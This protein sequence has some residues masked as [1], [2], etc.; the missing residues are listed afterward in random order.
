MVWPFTVEYCL[1]C[2]RELDRA[3]IRTPCCRVLVHKTCL[4][5][6]LAIT[7]SRPTPACP[8]C[9]Q[10]L[11]LPCFRRLCWRLSG[12]WSPWFECPLA[13]VSPSRS[14]LPWGL[15][16]EHGSTAT[17]TVFRWSSRRPRR[18]G[19]WNPS[20]ECL[21]RPH[22]HPQPSRVPSLPGSFFLC[23]FHLGATTTTTIVTTP[24]RQA[25]AGK[26]FFMFHPRGN[27]LGRDVKLSP[28]RFGR[29]QTGTS[30][31][32]SVL[33]RLN[34]MSCVM[35]TLCSKGSDTLF[36]SVSLC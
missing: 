34:G 29:R 10:E 23:S 32:L 36:L 16:T 8:H 24:R 2:A 3:V 4:Y 21:P 1:L 7:L 19:K 25:M 22:C 15:L 18:T 6:A 31:S 26:Y 35:E 27:R 30:Q 5:A 28:P 12:K 9:R 13:P 17:T 20:V 11:G 14:F 33:S